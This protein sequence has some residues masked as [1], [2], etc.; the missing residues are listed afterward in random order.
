MIKSPYTQIGV[1]LLTV[2]VSSCGGPASDDRFE[3]QWVNYANDRLAYHVRT[4]D[5]L[6]CRQYF[7]R[8]AAELNAL[9]AYLLVDMPRREPLEFY[10]IPDA[11]W[12]GEKWCGN[13]E[14]SG[15]VASDNVAF[16]QAHIVEHELVHLLASSIGQ[17]PD[18]FREGLAG[19]L[20]CE[21]TYAPVPDASLMSNWEADFVR[22]GSAFF[23]DYFTTYLLNTYG[24]AR[25]RDFY[26]QVAF[27]ASAEEVASVFLDT[28]GIEIESAWQGMVERGGNGM[29]PCVPVVPCTAPSLSAVETHLGR[30]CDAFIATTLP[31]ATTRL[32]LAGNPI[33]LTG[34]DSDGPAAYDRYVSATTI[35]FDPAG[36]RYAL[37]QNGNNGNASASLVVPENQLSV[38]CDSV[39]TISVAPGFART[40][41]FGGVTH[42][43]A[44]Q[45]DG[46]API[47][48]EFIA[49]EPSAWSF[50]VCSGCL[51]GAGTDCEVAPT[52][53]LNRRGQFW[54]RF[55]PIGASAEDPSPLIFGVSL[56]AVL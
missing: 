11:E 6:D 52:W 38:S 5:V 34:C 2:T 24:I 27:Q 1:L 46:D 36:Y 43:V 54:L 33:R 51:D 16:G 29:R 30:G 21:Q 47:Y 7:E 23:D 3:G 22:G 9:A 15:C 37:Y 50:E 32:V 20:N 55:V 44:V 8:L 25:F 12:D 41:L 45:T 14:A 10:Q 31:L 13:D 26:A 18:Y 49:G 42:Y 35:S 56:R 48:A 28:Y 39:E 53:A 17:P 4:E 19:A 40:F